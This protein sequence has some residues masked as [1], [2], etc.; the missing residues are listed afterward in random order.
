ML[1][2]VGVLYEHETLPV[3]QLSNATTLRWDEGIESTLTLSS[4]R[5]PAAANVTSPMKPCR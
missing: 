1:V 3:S 5:E 2:V 4:A